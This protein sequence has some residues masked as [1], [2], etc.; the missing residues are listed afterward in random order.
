MTAIQHVL[1]DLDGTLT[2]SRLGITRSW[3]AALV[4]HGYRA[5][6][7]AALERHIGPPTREVAAELL[8]T[9]DAAAIEAL[10]ATYR[11]RFSSV[12]LFENQVYPGV[13]ALLSQLS[14]A[15]YALFIC[16]SKPAVYARR[17]AEH[18]GFMPW[19][20]GVYGPELDG[21]RGEKTELLAHLVACEGITPAR[22]VLIGD[23]RHDVE[24]ARH[25]GLQHIGVLYG[26]GTADELRAAGADRLCAS[27]ADIAAAVHTLG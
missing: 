14:A 2:D 7:L 4:A 10:V 23:R 17:I 22:A 15:G 12:G 19:L 25:V 20:R 1:F 21:T 9:R 8:G 16:T 24:A 27:V 3:A 6:D 18:F 26:F 11:E 13:E 5:P